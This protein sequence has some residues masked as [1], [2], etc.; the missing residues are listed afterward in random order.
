MN[1]ILPSAYKVISIFVNAKNVLVD[2]KQNVVIGLRLITMSVV[3]IGVIAF[4][5]TL[6][7]QMVRKL[8]ITKNVQAI[9][10]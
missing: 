7:L 10:V 9:V 6:V 8:S 2:H 5:I 3:L 1:L 4:I